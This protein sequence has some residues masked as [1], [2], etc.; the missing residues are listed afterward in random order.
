MNNCYQC[1]YWQG[2]KESTKLLMAK[3]PQSM[4]LFKGFPNSGKC[5]IDYE[6]AEIEIDGDATAI[7]EVNANFGCVYFSV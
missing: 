6:W 4:D 1:K 3:Y 5:G 2:D 7:L